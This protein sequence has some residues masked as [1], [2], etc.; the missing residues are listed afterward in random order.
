MISKGM[1]EEEDEGVESDIEHGEERVD[2]GWMKWSFFL[3][4]SLSLISR[5]C[6]VAIVVL[7]PVTIRISSY[8]LELANCFFLVLF[9]SLLFMFCWW[10]QQYLSQLILWC[11]YLAMSHKTNSCYFILYQ[12]FPLFI[13]SWVRTWN[14]WLN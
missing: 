13:S 3:F 14:F 5:I 9:L 8:V 7:S 4:S 6:L 1:R 10:K 2:C 12:N 11:I